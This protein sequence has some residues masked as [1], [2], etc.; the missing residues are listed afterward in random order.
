M[1]WLPLLL[2]DP[3]PS[4]RLRVLREL[5]HK[6]ADDPEVRE[7]AVLQR[8]ES[9]V[10]EL[11]AAQ[12][13][14]GGWDLERR[15]GSFP[16]GR[17]QAAA[18]SLM[19]LG[20]LGLDRACPLVERAARFLFVQQLPDGSWPL[21]P[22]YREEEGEIISSMPLQTALPLAGLAMCGYAQDARTENG[23]EWLLS[24]RLDDGAWPTGWRDGNLRGVGG[25]RRLAHSRW[26]CR[27]NTTAAVMCLAHHPVRRQSDAARRGLDLLLGRETHDRYG[28]G[29]DTARLIGL[30]P[31]GGYLTYFARFDPGLMLDL[32]ARVGA[33]LQDERVAGLADFIRGEQGAFGLWEYRRFPQASRWVSFDLLRSLTGIDESGEWISLEPRTPF[34]AY[35]SKRKRY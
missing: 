18:F 30:E 32:C 16:G 34:K 29:F 19:Q 33:S 14:D 2:A 7:L 1:I 26:G 9:L 20:H 11:S 25:Y 8:D 13:P 23:Y 22:T 3:S 15:P 21:A 28:L 6:P 24:H 27:S 35:P 5:L 31:A 4:L 17:V 12:S 10:K